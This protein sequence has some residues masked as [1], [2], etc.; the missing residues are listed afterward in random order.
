MIPL[1]S[2]PPAPARRDGGADRDAAARGVECCVHQAAPA[3]VA[4]ARILPPLREH[5]GVIASAAATVLDLNAGLLTQPNGGDPR[6]PATS[7]RRV[8]I[9]RS[10]PRSSTRGISWSSAS[11]T[12]GTI[13]FQ[14]RL[15]FLANALKDHHLGLEESDDG[16]WSLYLGPCCWAR[17]TRR[18][19]RFTGEPH[20]DHRC[21]PSCRNELLPILPLSQAGEAR[22]GRACPLPAAPAAAPT[23]P[24]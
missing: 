23:F 5:E 20:R 21:Y 10:F 9:R 13:R 24:S 19:W 22:T 4:L 11:H 15:L 1:E 12:R 6:R 8:P 18:R 3:R 2:A 7:P 16:I 14:D 17:S